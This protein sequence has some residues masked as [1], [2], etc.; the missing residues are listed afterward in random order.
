M[1]GF[2]RDQRGQ[3]VVIVATS[4]TA[5]LLIVGLAADSGQ[6][7]VARR[8]MQEAADAGAYAGAVVIYQGGTSAQALEAATDDVERN[9]Y[10]DGGTT[11]VT[12]RVPTSGPYSGDDEYVEVII[13][14][15]VRTS[16]MSAFV[17]PLTTVSVRAVG[18]AEPLNNAYAIIALER[19]N[20]QN[21]LRLGQNGSISVDGAGILVNSTHSQAAYNQDSDGSNLDIDPAYT[22]DVAGGAVGPWDGQDDEGA[23]QQPNPFSGYPKPSTDGM[24][25][26][27]VMPADGADGSI[28]GVITINP[29]IWSIE[30]KGSGSEYI[31]M[32]S[33]VYIMKRGLNG[34]GQSTL[35][36]TATV[37]PSGT[38][39][40]ATTNGG[41]FI[42]NTTNDYPSGSSGSCGTINL[43]GNGRSVLFP[44]TSGTYSGMLVYQD[45]ACTGA[46]SISGNGELEASGTIYLPNGTFVMD[47]N[48]ATLTGSQ[49]VA[50]KVDVQQGNLTLTFDAGSTAQP[51]LPRLVE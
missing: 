1:S 32:T 11:S 37:S 6:L 18:G 17:R 45:E 38:P 19:G 12:V 30:I 20:V 21:A 50:N 25:T 34:T 48:N 10:T 2:L 39:P 28:D 33:G 49:I 46:M 26:Y 8:T 9:G 31:K 29:G 5:M 35:C 7:F 14:D 51:I 22:L 24:T 43:N 4:M 27:S 23:E 47:G 41:V 16:I 36:A 13:S 15:Q 3:A 44:M 40:C 42:F